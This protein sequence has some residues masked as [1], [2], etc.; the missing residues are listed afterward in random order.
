MPPGGMFSPALASLLKC[1]CISTTGRDPELK[2]A[3]CIIRNSG[4][5]LYK[6]HMRRGKTSRAGHSWPARK[7]TSSVV[8]LS[9]RTEGNSHP[10]TTGT[11]PLKA[12]AK[13]IGK[14]PPPPFLHSLPLSFSF[15]SLPSSSLFALSPSS[16]PPPFPPSP[17]IVLLHS[18]PRCSLLSSP[19][20]SVSP[21]LQKRLQEVTGATEGRCY[22]KLAACVKSHIVQHEFK[23]KI[24]SGILL[25]CYISFL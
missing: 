16:Q 8:S 7:K 1:L 13:H 6:T 21:G 23:G 3:V 18:I 17:P 11:P 24:Q 19:I 22:Y 20:R 12:M 9:A 2:A 5:N 25:H 4:I 10:T 14:I 15:L